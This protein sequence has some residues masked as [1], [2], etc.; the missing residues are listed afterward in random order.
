MSVGQEAAKAVERVGVKELAGEVD[1]KGRGEWAVVG[2]RE[3]EAG[4]AAQ[5]RDTPRLEEREGVGGCAGEPGEVGE[6]SVQQTRHTVDE[7]RGGEGGDGG[8]GVL[9][10][11]SAHPL[12]AGEDSRGGVEDEEAGG[13]GA[14]GATGGEE[15]EW[16]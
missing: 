6:E 4:R 11:E 15:E 10:E 3:K 2:E 9:G 16:R 13:T 8:D 7:M 12:P 5:Q 14:A 1:E